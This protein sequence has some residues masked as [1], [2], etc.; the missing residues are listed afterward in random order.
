MW[1]CVVCV[2]TAPSP[3]PASPLWVT[4][5]VLGSRDAVARP[6]GGGAH[7]GSSLGVFKQTRTGHLSRGRSSRLRRSKIPGG[8]GPGDGVAA[9]SLGDLPPLAVG[10]YPGRDALSRALRAPWDAGPGRGPA[11]LRSQLHPL[12]SPRSS[13]GGNL[14]LQDFPTPPWALPHPSTCGWADAFRQGK[15][16]E[17]R[18]GE[19]CAH[20]WPLTC[21]DSGSGWAPSTSSSS[22]AAHSLCPAYLPASP[23]LLTLVNSPPMPSP[24]PPHPGQVGPPRLCTWLFSRSTEHVSRNGLSA[25]KAGLLLFLLRV[26]RA[27]H[28]PGALVARKAVVK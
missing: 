11:G 2:P 25:L 18:V 24:A 6:P 16:T 10:S 28:R 17:L 1:V 9:P 15:S 7:Q 3:V 23:S 26:P 12:P 21:C 4:H 27:E 8:Q 20:A 13:L 14:I 5:L 22:R 19:L